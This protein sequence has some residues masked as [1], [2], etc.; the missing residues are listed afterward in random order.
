MEALGPYILASSLVMLGMLV[1]LGVAYTIW[2]QLN[3]KKKRAYF[4]ELH[5]DLKL[6]QEV[7]FGGGIFGTV[8]EIDGDRVAVKVR[9][10]AVLDVSRYAIQQIDR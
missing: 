2:S 5:A 8:K 1:L 3:M 7:M 4:K 9:S 10:G 6:G